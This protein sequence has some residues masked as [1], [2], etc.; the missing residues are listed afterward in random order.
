MVGL[1]FLGELELPGD[2]LR[3]HSDEEAA[4]YLKICVGRENEAR[5]AD[6]AGCEEDYGEVES[7]GIGVIE[8]KEDEEHQGAA[9][10]DGV[11]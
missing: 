5:G 8:G 2:K 3:E 10:G 6:E 7:G 4:P 9:H 11:H 1:F